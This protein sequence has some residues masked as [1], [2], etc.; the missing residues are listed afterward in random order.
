MKKLLILGAV[1]GGLVLAGM[2]LIGVYTTVRNEGTKI[3][4][5][6]TAEYKGM[7]AEYGQDRLSFV[8]QLGIAKGKTKAMV[9]I[10]DAAIGGRYNKPSSPEVDSGK[11]FSAVSEAY[12][13]LSG[14]NIFDKILEFVQTS[15]KKFAQRQEKIAGLVKDYDTWRKTGS[16]LHPTVV[17]WCGY[18]S[19]SLEIKINGNTYRGQ[20]ALDKMSTAIVGGD[21]NQIFDSGVDQ[22]LDT[23]GK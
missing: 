23:S 5:G 20:V 13:D 6:V 21:A 10:L 19:D 11:L 12:P 14:T 7:M 17:K 15:R 22:P 9:D 16:F 8:D 4:L 3:E 18:P 1:L 2:Y